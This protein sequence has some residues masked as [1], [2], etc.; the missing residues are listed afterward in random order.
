MVEAS[1][2]STSPPEPTDPGGGAT[3]G[4]PSPLPS[5]PRRLVAVFFSPGE[6]FSQLARQPRWAWALVLGAVLTMVSVAVIP[7]D[8]WVDMMRQGMLESG[9]PVPEGFDPESF[10]SLQKVFGVAGGGIFWFVMAFLVAGV[11]TVVFSFLLGDKGG[12]RQHLSVVSHALLIMGVGAILTTP[13][14]YLQGD[15]QASLN[16]G[17]FLP[18]DEGFAARFLRQLD[19]FWLW[20]FVAI[21]IGMHALDRRRSTGGAIAIVLVIPLAFAVLQAWI[22]GG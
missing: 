2:A 6:L 13:L 7:T 14:R 3:P 17:L 19:L 11:T 10:G 20:S 21:G 22:T 12:Y 16:V 8:M 5:I 18:V 1:D 15:L 4:E 9:R